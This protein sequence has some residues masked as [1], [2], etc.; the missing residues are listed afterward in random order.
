MDDKTSDLSV[1]TRIT[2]ARVSGNLDDPNS[3]GAMPRSLSITGSAATR[4]AALL[5]HNS[6]TKPPGCLRLFD[7][8]EERPSSNVRGQFILDAQS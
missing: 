6:S 2:A 1:E 4:H 7:R 5:G 3:H 8:R